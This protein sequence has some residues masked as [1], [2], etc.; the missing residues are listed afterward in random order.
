[1]K[2]HNIR[3]Y[4][5]ITIV[6]AATKVLKLLGKNATHLPGWIAN[7]LCPDFLNHLEK[8][9]KTVYITGTNGKT[10]VSN[11]TAEVLKDNGYDFVHNGKGS[12]LS[13][14]VISALLEKSTFFGKAKCKLA[15]LE[16]DEKYSVHIY[17]YMAPDYLCVTNLFRDSCKRNAHAEYIS[18][19]LE[20]QIPKHTKLLLNGEDLISNHLA[21]DNDRVYYGIE[22]EDASSNSDNIIKDIVACPHC[23]S[24]LDYEYIRY[25]H[26]GKAHCPRCD[27]GAPEAL[28]Y[29]ITAIDYEKGRCSI[30]TPQGVYDFKLLSDNITDMYNMMSSITILSEIGLSMEQIQKSYEKIKVTESRFSVTKAGDKEVVFMLAK[31]QNPIANSRAFDYVRHES[32]KKAVVYLPGDPFDEGFTTEIF[33]WIYDADVEFLNHESVKQ[34]V[35]AGLR[36]KDCRLRFLLAGIPDESL[37]CSHDADNAPACV[38]YEN[39]DKIFVIYNLHAYAQ[40]KKMY[41]EIVERAKE[42]SKKGGDK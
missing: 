19:I 28:D 20:S 26:I 25:N 23:G 14:G 7:N 1:M 29:A 39:V 5:T 34:V 2:K 31:S 32:G 10:T 37:V 8:P 42:H 16:V 13:E 18:D 17:P 33:A 22:C 41:D 4:V 21:F 11:L 38:D 15:L 24:L 9:E 27:F 12:N 35:L 3:F 36:D 30:R 40:A 6:K